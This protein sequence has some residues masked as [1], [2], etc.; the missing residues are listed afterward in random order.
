MSSLSS[1]CRLASRVDDLDRG[2][3]GCAED[4]ED[5][6]VVGRDDAIQLEVPLHAP[7]RVEDVDQNLFLRDG[8]AKPVRSGPICV[9]SP[10]CLWH[11]AQCCEEHLLA[12]RDV[13]GL[14]QDR[15]EL[16]DHLLPVRVG[17][18]AAERRAVSWRARRV[19]CPGAT[20]Q[21]GAADRARACR[22]AT[23]PSRRRQGT[24]WPSPAAPA[25]AAAPRAAPRAASLSA[26]PTTATPT[27]FA[28]DCE[29]ASKSPAHERR[30]R[31]RRDRV[32][33]GLRGLVAVGPELDDLLRRGR[34]GRHPWPSHRPA[35]RTRS[36]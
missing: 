16:L 23:C 5:G 22:S 15:L 2:R 25:R 19:P 36:W 10:P 8:R 14:R 7:R 24:P 34:A 21:R 3:G 18:P 33:N 4:A 35:S 20:C 12:V 30:R 11:L 13:A 32:N 29:S 28:F 27:P 6:A 26:S 9:P 1:A 31:L 17:Q